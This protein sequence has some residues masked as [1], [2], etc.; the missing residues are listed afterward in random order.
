[1]RNLAF[2][3]FA[4][5]FLL[6]LT[7]FAQN[8]ESEQEQNEMYRQLINYVPSQLDSIHLKLENKLIQNVENSLIA[9]LMIND[10]VLNTSDQLWLD[11]KIEQIATGF[12]RDGKIVLLHSV[13]G[14]LGCPDKSVDTI[15][16]NDIKI[17]Q[18][19][20][21]S[22]CTDFTKID[23]FIKVFNRKIYELLQ[24]HAPT[25]MTKKF[26]GIYTETNN[27]GE[28]I[29][30]KINRDRSFSFRIQPSLGH[31]G[32]YTIGFWK[33]QNDTLIL[34]SKVLSKSDSLVV[35]L[36]SGRWI[37]LDSSKFILKKDVLKSLPK[38]RWKLKKQ[39]FE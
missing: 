7:G 21:C 10:L 2:H 4:F 3:I 20:V 31:G 36:Q 28:I 23:H 18:L 39:S 37:N 22:S 9:L 1:M 34:N 19:H 24:I 25:S 30:L 27:N 17:Q 35:S 15:Q 5:M 13:G 12:F 14:Y 32:D 11:R 16:L 38:K 8:S 6:N 33:H 29:E 26:Y